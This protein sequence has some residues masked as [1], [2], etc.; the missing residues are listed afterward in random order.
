MLEKA[1]RQAVR[2][3]ALQSTLSKAMPVFRILGILGIIVLLF[4]GGLW[5]IP[6]VIEA[7]PTVKPSQTP[8]LTASPTITKT[9]KPTVTSTKIP[10][11][12]PTPLPTE[13]M[14][15]FGAEMVFIPAGE[16]IMG[17]T[18]QQISDA[19]SLCKP[20]Q[21]SSFDNE[22]PQHTIYLNS[23][24]INKFEV[25]N[26]EY[27]KCV[28][29]GNCSLPIENKSYTRNSYFG[30][31]QY[32]DYP[33]IYVSWNDANTYCEWAGKR[34]PTEAEWEKAARGI[35]G[36]IYPWGNT[37]D[38]SKL[39]SGGVVSDTTKVG[40]YPAGASPYGV[41][42][43]AG[44]VWEWVAD[45]FENNYYN[46]SPRNNPTGSSSGDLKVTRGGSWLDGPDFVR[47]A[48]RGT[49]TSAPIKEIQG[50][51]CAKDATP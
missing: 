7:I 3:A 32:D 18:D 1:E 21:P 16:F 25:T 9:P 20:C 45:W 44:N 2:S 12:E 49:W 11:Q 17:S 29:S 46:I 40:S 24:W 43:L 47:V 51:R 5:V 19:L 22:K 33:V 23:Y 50:F 15:D 13:I 41:M 31:A 6:K 14:D 34:L 27:K 26:A 36:R 35:D 39:N 38:S 30:N 4:W 42:D 8:T 10:T 28:D 48:L 37:F